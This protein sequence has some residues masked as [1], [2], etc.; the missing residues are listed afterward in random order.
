[1][2]KKSN[3]TMNELIASKMVQLKSNNQIN[4]SN[5]YRTLLHFIE[6]N[7]GVVRCC[8]CGPEFVKRMEA[9]MSSLSK[10]TRANYFACLKSIWYFANYKGYTC[11]AEF[12]FQR[13]SWESDKVKIP[14]MAKRTESWMTREEMTV[15]FQWWQG[16]KDGLRKRYIGMFLAS[17]LMNGANVA[18]LVRIRYN[19]DWFVTKGRVLTFVRHKT[20]EKS[21]VT[22]RVPVTEWLHSILEY[23]ADEPVRGGLV[24]GSFTKG[25]LPGEDALLKR[26]MSLNNGITKI[27]RK[28][29]PKAGLRGDVSVTFA[30]HSY[31]TVL[32]HLCAPFAMIEKALGH[33]G[34]GVGF[35]YIGAFSDDMLHQWNSQ[36]IL[37]ET[38]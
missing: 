31:S 13:K 33:S 14:K 17:Y 24:F 2:Q 15:L 26:I 30:R 6:R 28:E 22:V 27:L 36:L 18:D 4:T 16:M 38:A 7:Y 20:A 1:M 34:D 19:N 21:P 29:L 11:G 5:N 32:N 10:S 37:S 23:M 35:N 9:S 8:D 3:V 12:P 25:V